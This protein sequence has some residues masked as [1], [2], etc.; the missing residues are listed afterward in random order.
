MDCIAVSSPITRVRTRFDRV[1]DTGSP[2]SAALLCSAAR[3][4]SN[5]T[6]PNC[7]QCSVVTSGLTIIY[8][9]N[10]CTNSQADH[11]AL[12]NSGWAARGVLLCSAVLSAIIQGR[13]SFGLGPTRLSFRVLLC[14]RLSLSRI[15][16]RVPE[17][18]LIA[19]TCV[20][21]VSTIGTEG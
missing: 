11:A 15:Y 5:H 7:L 18:L 10:S 21:L 20:G 19:C 14:G 3:P 4:S 13:C 16:E 12:P 9:T 2:L 1:G 17:V 6:V 8:C